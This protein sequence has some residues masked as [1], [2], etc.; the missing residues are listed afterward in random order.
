MDG[1]PASNPY[2]FDQLIDHTN[3]ALGTFKQRY[4]FSDTYW[5]GQGAP[6]IVTTPGE[7]S[8]DGFDT[9]LTGS[10]MQNAMMQILGAAGIVLEHRYWGQSSPYPELTTANLQFLTVDQAIEDYKYFAETVQLPWNATTSNPDSVPWINLGC[11][12]S[13]LLTAYT[14]EKYPTLFAAAWASS[15]PVQAQGDFWQYFEPIEEG[16]PA[17]CSA[18]A[19]LVIAQIDTVFTSGTQEEILAL[20][21]SFGLEA[22]G[23]DDFGESL[24]A[25]LGSWQEMQAYSFQQTGEDI[26]YQWCD[27]MEVTGTGTTTYNAQSTGVGLP[28]ALNNWAAWFKANYPDKDCPGTGGA[29]YSTYDYSSSLYTNISVANQQRGWSWLVCTEL[30]YF[31]DGDPGNSSSIVSTYVTEAYNLRQCSYMFPNADGTPGN[32]TPSTTQVDSTYG[33]WNLVAENLFVVNGQY[34]PWR[35]VSLS[36]DWA[37]GFTDTA[38]QKIT[39]VAGGHHCW[40]FDA[41]NADYDP[42]VDRVITLGISTVKTWVLDWYQTHPNITSHLPTTADMVANAAAAGGGFAATLASVNDRSTSNST[43]ASRLLGNKDIAI[44][45]LAVNGVLLL[46]LLA[47]VFAMVRG[48]RRARTATVPT[49]GIVQGDRLGEYGYGARSGGRGV[50][51]T[52]QEKQ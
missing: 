21:T 28:A 2:F 45:S 43:E 32:Y 51:Q 29:C 41:E 33:G 6:I 18:D 13:G 25:Q 27:A 47:L 24:T 16:M 35:S 49:F 8:A 48:S 4:F 11:S 46:V 36:S 19:A 15:A 38:T 1:L 37:P 50:Y 30:G 40:D 5:N 52:L 22:L 17:N 10:S 23:D 14:Q 3:P 20:K 31:Q 39:V 42:D 7:Q 44:A 26:F 34:D 9:D 12:Y